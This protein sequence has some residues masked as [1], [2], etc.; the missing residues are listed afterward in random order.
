MKLDKSKCDKTG[1]TC[2]GVDE[3]GWHVHAVEMNVDKMSESDLMGMAENVV[4][5]D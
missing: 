1:C 4:K 3:S 5:G 2:T